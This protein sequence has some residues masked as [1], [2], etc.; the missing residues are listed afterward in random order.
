M[1]RVL[2]TTCATGAL[3]FVGAFPAASAGW[4]AEQSLP[5]QPPTTSLQHTDVAAGLSGLTGAV[6]NSAHPLKTLRLDPMAASSAD[7]LSNGVAL[8][9]DGPGDR[10]VSTTAVTSPLSAGGG[11]D[12][13]PLVG[14][15]THALPGS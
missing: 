14:S 10:P 5:L 7:P 2:T 11:L 4:A 8:A 6:D 12:S 1:F 3:L 15:L 9:P 13:V